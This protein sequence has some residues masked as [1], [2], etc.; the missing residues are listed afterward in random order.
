MAWDWSHTSEGVTVCWNNLGRMPISRLMEMHAEWLACTPPWHEHNVVHHLDVTK[1]DTLYE[2][3]AFIHDCAASH[4]DHL[5]QFRQ[6]LTDQIWDCMQQFRL[7]TNGG[8]K[9]YGCP[10]GCPPH[11]VSFSSDEEKDE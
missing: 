9:A 10:F 6:Y 1:H 7:C 11:L 5:T 2:H 3:F 4:S 8:W